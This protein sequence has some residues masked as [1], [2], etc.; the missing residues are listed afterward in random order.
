MLRAEGIVFDDAGRASA[1]QHITAREIAELLGLPIAADLA[2]TEA[3]GDGSLSP[4]ALTT[5]EERFLHQLNEASGPQAAGAV[6]RLLEHWRSRG[7]ELQYGTSANASCAPIIKVGRQTMYVIRF[8]AK[9]AEI[10]FSVLR[11]R[12]PFDDPALREELRQRLNDAPGVDIPVAKLE[13]YPSIKNTQLANIAVFDVVVA[14][15]DWF[16]ATVT[17]SDEQEG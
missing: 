13:L 5:L 3:A 12:K 10:P 4:Q 1:D 11:K 14:A 6:Q 9:T 7:G 17:A 16:M 15:L 2:E 8:Y